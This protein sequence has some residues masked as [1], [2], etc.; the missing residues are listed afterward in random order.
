MF[1]NTVP[2][3]RLGLVVAVAERSRKGSIGRT[4]LMKLAYFLQVVRN[5]PLGYHFTLY[6]YGPFDSD[7]LYDL[8]VASTLQAVTVET[9]EYSNGYYGYEVKP[10][11]MAEK[12]KSEADDFLA[13]YEADIS[14]VIETF[15]DLSTAQLELASTLVY[16]DREAVDHKRESTIKDLARRVKEIKPHF[17]DQTIL[18]RAKS[19]RSDG[20][21]NSNTE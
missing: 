4:G 14:W 15:G 7:V 21:L 16:I 3:D 10:G 19:L 6:S 2:W 13:K 12:V 1:E 9:K 11:P 17:S 5:V 20:L 8:D 18:D